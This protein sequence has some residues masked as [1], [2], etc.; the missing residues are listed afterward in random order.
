MLGQVHLSK[1][2]F[3]YNKSGSL[4]YKKRLKP[5][6][7]QSLCL[8]LSPP[9]LPLPSLSPSCLSLPSP[10]SP[11]P[12]SLSLSP[13]SIP[14]PSLYPSQLSLSLYPLS[15][16]LPSLYPSQL[17]PLYISPPLSI[18]LPSLFS[19]SLPLPSLFPPFSFSPFPLSSP[20]LS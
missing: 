2:S 17:S 3:S 7:W 15:I 18:P 1:F 11:F 4:P 12:L 9:S 5:Q 8:P 19:L 16:P 14:L 20:A 13:L 6:W 10:L